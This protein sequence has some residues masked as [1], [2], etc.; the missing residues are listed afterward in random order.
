[1]VNVS[2]IWSLVTF[3]SFYLQGHYIIEKSRTESTGVFNCAL[4]GTIDSK[5][6]YQQLYV[7]SYLK[8][9]DPRDYLPA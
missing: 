2:H 8:E 6:Q 3:D 9:C 7:F 4:L 1:M 5:Y